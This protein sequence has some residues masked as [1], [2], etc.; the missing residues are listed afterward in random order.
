MDK[1]TPVSITITPGTVFL[2]FIIGVGMALAW[3]LRDIVLVVI[4]SVVLASAIEP[5]AKW[6]ERRRVPRAIGVL[7]IYLIVGLLLAAL[8]YVFFPVLV[9]DTV[10]LLN[11]LPTYTEGLSVWNPLQ[12]TRLGQLNQLFSLKEIFQTLNEQLSNLTAGFFTTV[13]GLFGGIVSF[14]LIIILSFYLAVQKDGVGD[15]LR[16][17]VPL[18]YEEYI[19]DLWRRSQQKIG[20]W[21]QGQLLLGAIIAILTYLGLSI[22]GVDNALFLAVI[23]GLTELIPIFGLLIAIIPAVA[24]AMLQEG[25]T[26]VFLVIGLYLII[27]QFESNLIYPLVVKKIIGI[28]PILTILTLVIGAKLAGFLGVLLS[29]PVAAVLM[30]VLNDIEKNKH[31]KIEE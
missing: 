16:I 12:T 27:Q 23:A 10:N 30:E 25:V 1:H 26:L 4:T 13:S 31:P 21:M 17:I 8:F 6:F 29:V 20:L 9:T 7:L 19:I 24:V 14:A 5:G 3:Y 15:F 11:V 22:L 2:V 28:P 18:K